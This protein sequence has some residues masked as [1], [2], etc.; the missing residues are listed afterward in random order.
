LVLD[1]HDDPVRRYLEV[2]R[3]LAT[4]VSHRVR[5]QLAHDELDVLDQCRRSVPAHW[6]RAVPAGQLGRVTTW[7]TVEVLALVVTAAALLWTRCVHRGPGRST[8]QPRQAAG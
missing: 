4:A 2:H 3:D 7:Y 5:D 1:T 6:A 8:S